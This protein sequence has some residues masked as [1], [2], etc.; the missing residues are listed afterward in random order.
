MSVTHETSL[1][2]LYNQTYLSKASAAGRIEVRGRLVDKETST[3][4]EELAAPIPKKRR[5]ELLS[6]MVRLAA[7]AQERGELVIDEDGQVLLNCGTDI[8]ERN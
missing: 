4:Y 2:T 3:L 6:A 7:Q 1:Q 5:G 8:S